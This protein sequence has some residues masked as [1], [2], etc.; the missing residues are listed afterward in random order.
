MKSY[1]VLFITLLSIGI[2]TPAI[3]M[4][5]APVGATSPIQA[6]K[7]NG[8]KKQTGKVSPTPYQN[9]RIIPVTAPVKNSR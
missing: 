1:N 2:V 4:V 8:V 5:H 3:A 7:Q 6:A 9:I